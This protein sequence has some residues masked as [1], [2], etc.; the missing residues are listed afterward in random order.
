MNIPENVR[1]ALDRL[2]SAGF[3]AYLVGGCVRDFVRGVVPSDYD[4]TTP[5]TPEETKAVFGDF[6]VFLQGEKHGTVGVIINTEKLEITTHRRDG[7]YLDHRRPE[8]VTFSRALADDLSRRDFTVN[9]LA[10]SP[11]SGL[12]DLFGG[13]ADIENKV[14]KCV[15]NAD[16]RFDEDALRILRALRFSSTLGF[17]IEENTKK[18]IFENAHLLKTVSGER[19]REEIEKWVCGNGASSVMREFGSVF[20]VVLGEV[21]PAFPDFI[22]LLDGKKTRM[23][24]LLS[25]CPEKTVSYLKFSNE[26]KSFYRGVR[27][28]VESELVTVF[29]LKLAVSE[30]GEDAVFTSLE[31]KSAMHDPFS[32]DLFERLEKALANGECMHKRDLKINGADLIGLGIAPGTKMGWVIDTLF[33]NVLMDKIPNESEKLKEFAKSLL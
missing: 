22:D 7:D 6:P 28:L 18:A 31:I 3:E 16:R 12:V 23:A 15:G 21:S 24:Y 13:V 27:R 14:I 32:R 10:Y 19:V 11:R 9:A 25:S 30:C 4:I 1:I 2:W 26:D 17:E 20:A 33:T 8:S 29:D 5:S